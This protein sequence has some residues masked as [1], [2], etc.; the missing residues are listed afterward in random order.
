MVAEGQHDVGP[1]RGPAFISCPRQHTKHVRLPPPFVQHSASTSS[2]LP[3]R[4]EHGVS[5]TSS[6]YLAPQTQ[7]SKSLG[8]LPSSHQPH[9]ISPT[10]T[11]TSATAP[12]SALNPA[13]AP[14]SSHHCKHL[15]PITC[16]TPHKVIMILPHLYPTP[17]P[18]HSF[19]LPPPGPWLHT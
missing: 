16:S 1:G 6:L 17:D 15:A 5:S 12:T 18:P 9:N 13:F 10:T 14:P 19:L 4:M 8:L 11:A 3:G 2:A 7:P